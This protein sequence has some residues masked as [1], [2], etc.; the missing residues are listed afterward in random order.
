VN[1]TQRIALLIAGTA[2]VT[3]AQ[4][5]SADIRVH[6][7]GGAR[8][9]FGGGAVRAH[10][11]GRHSS[12]HVGGSIWLGGGY[13]QPFAQPP[14]PPPVAC[15]CGEQIYYPP[16][17]PAPIEYVG[18]APVAVAEAPMARF[19]IGAFLGGVEVDGTHEG[20]DAGLVAQ[21]RLTRGL[22]IEAELAKNELADGL[23]VD[24][25]FMAGLQLELSPQRRMT[26]YLAAA[27]GTTQVQV[28][29]TW[30]DNQ[31]LAE[32][33]GGLRYRLSP[34]LSLFGDIRVG[35]RQLADSAQPVA[36]GGVA[37]KALPADQENYTRA[38][39]GGLVTF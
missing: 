27:L 3:T 28:G 14:P 1:R 26:P 37:A 10:W 16:I 12:V 2:L 11:V 15:N 8:I 25:R 36:T 13:Y 5:A 17:A 20:R 19:G 23:R 22:I 30:E 29:D 39:L 38:R 6:F 4:A 9:H 33:G 24:R 32:I 7:G 18:V 34:R 31:A 21:Y 35:Q